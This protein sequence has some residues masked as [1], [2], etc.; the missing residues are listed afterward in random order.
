M[1]RLLYCAPILLPVTR[2]SHRRID[3]IQHALF[4]CP[5]LSRLAVGGAMVNGGA[6][7]RQAYGA[8]YAAHGGVLLGDRIHGKAAELQGNVPLVIP[9]R[10]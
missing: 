8:V 9:L 5:A 4:I 3:G 2:N 1:R 6:D 10:P 7:H